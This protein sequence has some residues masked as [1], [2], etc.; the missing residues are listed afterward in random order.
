MR[1]AS[2]RRS[3]PVTQRDRR[4]S[5]LPAA[6]TALV[7]AATGCSGGLFGW[8]DPPPDAQGTRVLPVV[9]PLVQGEYAFL[10]THED[11]SPVV[12]D[13][14]RPM[15]WTLNPEGM[16]PGADARIREAFDTV[17]RY[18]GLQFVEDPPTDERPDLRRRQV[19]RDRYGDRIAPV[20]VAFAR[21]EDVADM[22]AEVA[23]LAT[24]QTI[25]SG[26]GT[27]RISGGQLVVDSEFTAWALT[28]PD[29]Q[30][31]LRMVLMHEMG[32]LIGLAHVSNPSEVMSPVANGFLDFGPGDQ[33]GLARAG[34]GRC[35]SDA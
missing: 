2:L 8:P 26:R 6:A 30:A 27:E 9:I 11:G 18:S 16:P 14:C 24:P 19:Q 25:S 23:A 29:G 13:P 4:R 35:F 32:H 34:S 7:L 15:H 33:Q 31:R 20:L 5:V 1:V 3:T 17:S 12:P 22:G 28:S 21:A 10:E